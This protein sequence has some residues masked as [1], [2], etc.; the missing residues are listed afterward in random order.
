MFYR[1]IIPSCLYVR[2]KGTWSLDGR[3]LSSTGE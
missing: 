2:L 1:Q 3:A